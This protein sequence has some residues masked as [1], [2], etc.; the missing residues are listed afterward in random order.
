MLL[1]FMAAMLVSHQDPS[2]HMT[3]WDSNSS[4]LDDDDSNDNNLSLSRSSN[5]LH[6]DDDDMSRGMWDISSMYYSICHQFEDHSIT[7]SLNS[8]DIHHCSMN[9]DSF[10]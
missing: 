5:A 4:L 7:D 6:I 8:D 9:Y 2:S 1:T 3:T 10:I